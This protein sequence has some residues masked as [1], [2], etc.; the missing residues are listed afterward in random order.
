MMRIVAIFVANDV[1]VVVIDVVVVIV[2]VVVVIMV[3]VVEKMF[4]HIKV[5]LIKSSLRSLGSSDEVDELVGWEV[6]IEKFRIKIRMAGGKEVRNEVRVGEVGVVEEEIGG[7]EM[8]VWLGQLRLD[9]YRVW[10]RC[11]CC[12]GGGCTDIGVVVRREA[13]EMAVLL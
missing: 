13:G 4:H 10:R 8:N 3:V 1:G 11:L 12:F 6:S 9:D 5:L 2:D 7:R